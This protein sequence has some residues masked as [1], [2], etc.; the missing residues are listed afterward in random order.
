MHCDPRADYLIVLLALDARIVAT[1]LKGNR[2]IPM[3]EFVRGPFETSLEPDEILTE[4]SIAR[5]E[6]TGKEFFRKYE[7]GH[8]D[9]GLAFVALRAWT[10]G[11]VCKRSLIYVSGIGDFPT[12]L[13]ELESHLKNRHVKDNFDQVIDNCLSKLESAQGL[14]TETA[15][16]KKLLSTLLKRALS[17][18]FRTGV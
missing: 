10:E 1:S 13:N 9:F 12:R 2:V 16:R 15:F 17:D 14:G 3:S 6:D 4:I 11:S 18:L 7:F 5:T 8:G